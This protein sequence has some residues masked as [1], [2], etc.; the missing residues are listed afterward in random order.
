MQFRQKVLVCNPHKEFRWIGKLVFKH[1]FDGEHVFILKDNNNGTTIFIQ[2][3]RFRGI[4][5]PFLT[6]TLNTNTLTG[7]NNMNEALKKRCEN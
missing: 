2:Y 5:V 4:L 6:K 1:I 7:Y 3:E